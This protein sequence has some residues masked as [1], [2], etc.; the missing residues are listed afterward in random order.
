MGTQSR[1][2]HALW[3]LLVVAV[4]SVQCGPDFSPR[5]LS[6]GS[7]QET[8]HWRKT[9]VFAL[10]LSLSLLLPLHSLALVIGHWQVIRGGEVVHLP[11]RSVR[12]GDMIVVF[13]KEEFP[14]DV[15]LLATSEEMGKCYTEVRGCW[16]TSRAILYVFSAIWVAVSSEQRRWA[17]VARA[18]CAACHVLEAGAPRSRMY[19]CVCVPRPPTWMAR[20]I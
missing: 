18:P 16:P 15:I 7:P 8:I 1:T 3:G 2:L 19:L 10:S 12:T 6:A 13:D 14:A 17:C 11:W 4:C 20:P 5:V 9:F